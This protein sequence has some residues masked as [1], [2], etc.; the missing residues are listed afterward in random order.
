MIERFRVRVPAGAV[1]EFSSPGSTF[2][3]DF[4]FGIR[5]TPVL[6]QKHVKDPGH[7]AKSAHGKLQRHFIQS[8]I[9]RVYVCL[10]GTCHLHFWQ[11]DRDL[12]HATVVTWGVEWIPK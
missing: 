9:G 8:H 3:A 7:S 10:A 1:G 5:S 2:C 12:L 4:Y 11:H 6:P